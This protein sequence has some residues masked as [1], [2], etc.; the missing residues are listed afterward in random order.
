MNE[1]IVFIEDCTNC[2]H[3]G[4]E[5]GFGPNHHCRTCWGRSKKDVPVAEEPNVKRAPVTFRYDSI[6]PSFLKMMAEIGHYAAEKYGSWEQY[7]NARLTGEK[8]PINHIYEHLR[9]YQMGEPYDHFE[10]DVGRHLVAVAYNAMM[11]WFYYKRW[12]PER[13]PLT[14]EPAINGDPTPGDCRCRTSLRLNYPNEG[15]FGPC[16]D[17]RSHQVQCPVAVRAEEKQKGGGR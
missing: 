6:N 12:G 9:Q 2:N 3:T 4:R 16:E 5:P 14:I 11:E 7:T 8:S 10:G 1:P 15:W 17:G 13:H